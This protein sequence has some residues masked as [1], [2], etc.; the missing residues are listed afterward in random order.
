MF[1]NLLRDSEKK[2]PGWI[3]CCKHLRKLSFYFYEYLFFKKSLKKH[4]KKFEW[5]FRKQPA[6]YLLRTSLNKYWNN[7][8]NDGYKIFMKN[9]VHLSSLI[10]L[11][12]LW[13]N[14]FLKESLRNLWK[15]SWWTLERT[16][17]DITEN[18]VVE[19][20]RAIYCHS[21]SYYFITVEVLLERHFQ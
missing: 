19:F 20:L 5:G 1:L 8:L 7:F 12:S 15:I 4:W 13:M 10:V 16:L 9:C 18:F 17:Q 2:I 6:G 11:Y 21:A 14:Y 3:E